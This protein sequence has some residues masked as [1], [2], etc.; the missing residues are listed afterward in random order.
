MASISLCLQHRNMLSHLC[1]RQ[2]VEM[3]DMHSLWLMSVTKGLSATI[4]CVQGSAAVK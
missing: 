3:P 1:C 4:R 2:L